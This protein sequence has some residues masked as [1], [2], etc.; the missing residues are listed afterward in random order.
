MR[1]FPG[2]TAI[3][4]SRRGRPAVW[5]RVT[6]VLLALLPALVLL[7]LQRFFGRVAIASGEK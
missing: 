5:R 3:P 6:V 7:V 4:A 2:T 1:T